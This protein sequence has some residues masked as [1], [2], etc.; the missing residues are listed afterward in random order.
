MLQTLHF[1]LLA[2]VLLR[3]H[4]VLYNNFLVAHQ[5][6]PRRLWLRDSSDPI[7]IVGTLGP[8]R[9]TGPIK[10]HLRPTQA[11][12]I[13]FDALG[14]LGTTLVRHFRPIQIHLAHQALPQ[15]HLGTQAH[16]NALGPLST[17]LSTF[18]ITLCH[19]CTCQTHLSSSRFILAHLGSPWPTQFSQDHSDSHGP[20]Q[21]HLGPSRDT[22]PTQVHLDPLRFT[23]AHLSTS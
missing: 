7:V 2:H 8:F 17:T 20:V 22:Q 12:Q 15:A 9:C 5:T 3:V 10:H 13:H 16:L 11:P 23:Q 14:P 18:Q 4:L 6:P 21:V 1:F 19:L